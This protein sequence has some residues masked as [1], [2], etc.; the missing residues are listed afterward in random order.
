M[1]ATDVEL[2]GQPGPGQTQLGPGQTQS[3]PGQTV[4]VAAAPGPVD[5]EGMTGPTSVDAPCVGVGPAQRSQGTVRVAVIG[6]GPQTLQTL[7]VWVKPGG[8]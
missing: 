8:I 5:M 3:G 4:A 7:T 1:E 6:L 2:E